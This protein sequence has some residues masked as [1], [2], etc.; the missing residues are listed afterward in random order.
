MKKFRILAMAFA[1][2]AIVSCQKDG[3]ETPGNGEQLTGPTYATFNFNI[4]TST[5]AD[6]D[7]NPDTNPG[8]TADD[9]KD[10]TVGPIQLLIFNAASQA[11]EHNSVVTKGQTSKTV[12]LT[13]G[14]KKIFFVAN[15]EKLTTL[16]AAIEPAA[17]V[18]GTATLSDFYKLNFSAGTPQQIVTDKTTARTFSFKNLY[19]QSNATAG[20]LAGLPM[21]NTNGIT[22]TLA[23]GVTEAQ[24][25]AGTAIKDGVSPTNTFSVQLYYM[26]AK[27]RLVLAADI[28]NTTATTKPFISDVTYTIRNLARVTNYIQNVPTANNP[29]SYYYNYDKTLQTDFNADFD[30]ASALT[31][32]VTTTA[33]N[34]LYVPENNHSSILRGQ[35]SYFAI[36]AFFNPT[37]IT[38]VAYDLTTKV[39]YTYT[40][41]TTTARNYIYTTKEVQGIPAGTYFATV[42]LFQEAAWMMQNNAPF[43]E[44]THREDAKKLV[45]DPTSTAPTVGGD[46][47]SFTGCNSYYRLDLGVGTGATTQYGVLRSNKYDATINKITGP[48]VP[49]EQDLITDPEK[50][51]SA[52]TYVS[53]TIIPAVWTPL[54]QSG[55]L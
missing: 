10:A 5:Y 36:K 40:V 20:S 47:M 18:V 37:I 43:V 21:S 29:Q 41:P 22:Y 48:G 24:A 50:P 49:S 52:R 55:D 17:F 32:P 7:Y 34:Y 4:G 19:E 6:A 14:Q 51:V 54:T 46:Y 53:A 38:A 1:A 12:L 23:A 35:S 45:T 26:V 30:Y 13:A 2:M 8:A 27:A 15:T 25:S 16:T 44:A 9:A 33:A 11:L 3:A 39:S 28:L 42:A 31:V